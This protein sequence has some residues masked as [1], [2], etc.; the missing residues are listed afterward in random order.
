[1][2][3]RRYQILG[4]GPQFFCLSVLRPLVILSSK[5]PREGTFS[6][7]NYAPDPRAESPGA[8]LS[9]FLF[10]HAENVRD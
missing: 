9:S 6:G 2:G 7:I 8:N 4:A 3:P 1:M 5:K 10:T